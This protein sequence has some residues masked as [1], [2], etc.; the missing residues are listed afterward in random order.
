MLFEILITRPC[1]FGEQERDAEVLLGEYEEREE[2][3]QR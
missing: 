1:G 3:F 2:P